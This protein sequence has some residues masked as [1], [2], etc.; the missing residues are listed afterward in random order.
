MTRYDPNYY[1]D[2]ANDAEM[3]Q[4]AVDA[5]AADGVRVT[6]PR[7]NLRTGQDIWIIPQAILLHSGSVV[8]LDNCHLRQADG[9][10][11]NLFRNAN[12][13]TE[14]A[15]TRAGRQYDIRICGVGHAVLDGGNHNGLIERNSGQDGR[16]HIIVNT[17]LHFHN[18]ER[19]TL[20]NLNILHPRWWGVTFHYC[21]QGRVSNIRFMSIG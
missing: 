19:V 18:C 6:V 3:I 7:R 15:L 17:M 5:A 1:L 16:P 2:A 4:H 11:D 21:A 13:R 14:R 10:F 8:A 12:A 20:E 9:C